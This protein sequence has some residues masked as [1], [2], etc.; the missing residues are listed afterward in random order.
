MNR[1]DEVRQLLHMTTAQM[2]VKAG[3][4]LLIVRDLDALHRHFAESI[5]TEVRTNNDRGRPT[6]LILPVG[7]V[8]QYPLLGDILNQH[9]IILKQ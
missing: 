7:P 6:K 5:A 2:R 1:Q 9:R 8:G 4:H 3:D